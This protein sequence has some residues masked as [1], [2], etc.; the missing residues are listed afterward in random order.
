MTELVHH[1]AAFVDTLGLAP[2]DSTGSGRAPGF[3]P[4]DDTAGSGKAPEIEADAK[5]VGAGGSG[6]DSG[7]T[8]TGPNP[9]TEPR[10][11]SLCDEKPPR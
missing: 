1:L 6:S 7:N 9:L 3:P 11:Q 8:D 2:V 10:V 4:V 5:T